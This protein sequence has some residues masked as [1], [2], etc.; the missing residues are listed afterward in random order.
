MPAR[1]INIKY[2]TIRAEKVASPVTAL[3]PDQEDIHNH[4]MAIIQV[5]LS[6]R[7]VPKSV[8]WNNLERRSGPYFVL[9]HRIR[10][11]CRRKTI[12]SVSKSTFDSL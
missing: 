7:L 12:I 8:T 6:F 4:F 10:V 3:Q 2:I 11:R 9:F 1:L 5:N